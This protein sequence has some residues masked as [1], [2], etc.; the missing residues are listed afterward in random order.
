MIGVGTCKISP[1][2]KAYVNQVLESERLSYGPFT[3]EF[4]RRFAAEHACRFA[5]MTNSG[6]SSLQIALAALKRRHGWADGDEVIVPALTFV[7]TANIVIQNNM[8][9]VFVDVD[10]VFYELDPAKV[11]AKIGPRTRCM[12]PVHLFGL[13][14]DM[15]P[16]MEIAARHHLGVI[17][18]SAETMFTSYKGRPVG[19]FG[20]IGCF[21]TYVA[22]ILTTGVGG[23][24]TTNDPDLAT[25]LRS[26]MNHGRDSIYISIDDDQGKSAEELRM[27]IKKRFSF[28]DLGYSYRVTE[29]EGALGLAEFED[30]A[31]MMRK[32]R[33][34]GTFL[35]KE[36]GRFSDRIQVP[37]LREHAEH[38]FM[39]FPIVLREEPKQDLVEFLEL[40]RIE[41]RDM[42]PMV[43][44]PYYASRGV[45][46]AEY[47]VAQW[48]NRNG[49]YIASHHGL[50]AT[51]REYIVDTFDRFF[52]KKR[53]KNG[54]STLILMLKAA[55]DAEAVSLEKC[56]SDIPY[57]S[58]DEVVLADASPAPLESIL[59]HFPGKRVDCRGCGKGE[60]LRRA[61]AQSTGEDVVVLGLDGADRP[62]DAFE[63]LLH[64]GKGRDLVIASRFVQNGR[65]NSPRSAAYR[66]LGNR[67]FTLLLNLQRNGNLTDSNNLF[68]GFKRSFYL[69]AR[70]KENGDGVAFELSK[71]A[72]GLKKTIVEIPTTE[73]AIVLKGKPRNHLNTALCFLRVLC[74]R[75]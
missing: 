9:P 40:N 11:E 39:M 42:L 22:H 28:V 53:G 13:P 7:A 57:D 41:T 72:L 34:N 15:D 26:L 47:P 58:F 60:S 3:Q 37:T 51:Q 54:T 30:R 29:M 45:V 25:R 6:T 27:I 52:A 17:E 55:V 67:F 71:A 43:N 65:R 33:E 38:A 62:E 4:E 48:I 59:A 50:T 64:L 24:C 23:L 74:R 16:L 63:I 75:S 5:C 61:M 49:F 31:D 10:P 2:A 46:E 35:I 14:C 70:T 44:Q 66:S 56:L 32:R 12:I 19:S 20:D 73:N 21:S 36:L 68:R 1:K 18:D 8:V 69:E